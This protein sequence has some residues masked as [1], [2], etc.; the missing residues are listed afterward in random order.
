[1][2]AKNGIETTFRAG[3]NRWRA[4]KLTC[5]PMEQEENHA[6]CGSETKWENPE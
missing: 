4:G 1:M 2:G 6:G 5:K 3:E